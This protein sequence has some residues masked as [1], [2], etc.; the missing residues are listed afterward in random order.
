MKNKYLKGISSN[1]LL[2]GLVSFLT[3]ASSDM[4]MPIL[5]MFIT[6]LGGAGLVI[7]LIGGLRDSITSILQVFCGYWSD[8][9]GKRKIFVSTGYMTSSIFKLF[10]AFSTIW[11][12]VLV[13]AG[14]ERIGKGLRTA[15]RDAIIADS[16]PQERGKGFGIHR[17]LDT[18]GAILGSIVVFVLFWFL[19]FD[20]KSI[21]LVAGII[22]FLALIPLYFVKERKRNPQD[23]T[24]KIELKNLPIPLKLFILISG[25]FALANFSYMFFILRAQEAF[26]GKLSIGIPIL[27]YILFNIFYAV[28]AIPFGTLS[29]KIGRKKVIVFGYLLFSLT[30]LGFAFFNSLIAFIILFALYGIV[31]AIIDGNQRAYVSDLSS[32]KLR[33]TALGTY[34]TTIGLVA[35]PSSLIAGFLWQVVAPSI[36]FIY[37]SLVSFI[38]VVLFIAF[39]NY[40]KN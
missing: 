38:S 7:G 11:Q 15:P 32:E 23:I 19:E 20:F 14:L 6:A 3:D 22:G 10:L 12:H 36:T 21:I 37:G 18:S 9:T 26:T 30:S 35:L 29:D 17:A 39:R 4:I 1:I 5:P 2:L 31:Y 34:H 13:F 28:F 8:K 33:A 27:L 40:F 25:I 16:M 24:L